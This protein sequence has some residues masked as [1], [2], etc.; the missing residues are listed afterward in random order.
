M[1]KIIFL[2]GGYDLEMLEIKK[3]LEKH[4]ITYFDKKLSW[5]NALLINY[6]EVIAQYGNKHDY[7]L[8]GIELR[9]TGIN[10]LPGNY[11][12][13]DHHNE[14]IDR[15]SAL[16][17]VADILQI[18]LTRNQQLKA[19][20]DKGYIPAMKLLGATNKEIN[21]I[22]QQDRKAQ[23]VTEKDELLSS[24]AIE[25]K[26]LLGDVTVIEALS[27]AFSPICDRLYPY[28]KLLLYTSQNLMYYGENKYKLVNT[29]QK[30][31][32]LGK[33]F[34]GGNDSGFFGIA[35]GYYNREEI[36]NFVETIKNIVL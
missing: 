16:E 26:K 2:L 7:L 5:D 32:A 13:I 10:S 30:E 29:F 35:K 11:Q 8:Y 4:K 36:L 33:M 25:N 12:L 22:R 9:N 3:M 17:Q 28:K 14:Y 6:Q 34:H 23:G 19:A 21:T 1:S 20:N 18:P 31:I 24:K 15:P 27:F